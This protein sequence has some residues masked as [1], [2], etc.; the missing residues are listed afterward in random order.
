[1]R[2]MQR[3][4]ALADALMDEHGLDALL[5]LGNSGYLVLPRDREAW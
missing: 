1:M 5:L 2:E 4:R 3:R